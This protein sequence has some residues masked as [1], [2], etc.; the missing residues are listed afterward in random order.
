MESNGVGLVF[1][2]L[3]NPTFKYESFVDDKNEL[4]ERSILQ[5]LFTGTEQGNDEIAH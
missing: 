1:L 5:A 3:V 4:R 2:S